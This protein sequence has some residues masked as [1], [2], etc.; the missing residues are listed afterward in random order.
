MQVIKVLELTNPEFPHRM[1]TTQAGYP[2]WLVLNDFGVC[3]LLRVES[4][5]KPIANCHPA[6]P[7]D[8]YHVDN[9]QGVKLNDI[10][11]GVRW[12]DKE[13]DRTCANED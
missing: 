8:Q 6:I 1:P 10:I 12:W 3:D 5:D 9:I 2:A 4:R 11:C 7:A 13:T